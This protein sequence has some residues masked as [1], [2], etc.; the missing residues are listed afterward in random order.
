MWR[1]IALAFASSTGAIGAF[2]FVTILMTRR[3]PGKMNGP[4]R[5]DVKVGAGSAIVVGAAIIGCSWKLF[6]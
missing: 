4:N 3:H 1:E 2:L 6:W 5:T